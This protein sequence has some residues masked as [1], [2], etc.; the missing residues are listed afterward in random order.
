MRRSPFLL[1]CVATAAAATT[2]PLNSSS[3]V[4]YDP[5]TVV[6]SGGSA[7]LLHQ[8][9]GTGADGNLSV[10]SSTFN[11]STG[12]SGSRTVADGASWSR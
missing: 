10:T 2:W 9:G 6:V 3:E 5:T 7:R 1:L 8:I 4:D 12:L 11:L